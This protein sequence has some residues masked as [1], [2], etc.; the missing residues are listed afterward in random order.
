MSSLASV[1]LL[2][3]SALAGHPDFLPTRVSPAGKIEWGGRSWARLPGAIAKATTQEADELMT[4]RRD[5]PADDMSHRLSR[6]ALSRAKELADALREAANAIESNGEAGAG[7]DSPGDRRELDLDGTLA[8]VGSARRAL[9][10]VGDDIV[11]LAAIAG[12]PMRNLG[13]L[14]DLSETTIPLR[15]ARTERLAQYARTTRGKPRVGRP[16]LGAALWNYRRDGNGG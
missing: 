15:L 13:E 9:E 3:L 7:M 11:A 14:T 16:E 4:A 8:G 12:Y 1:K 5:L 2:S 6:D 10:D